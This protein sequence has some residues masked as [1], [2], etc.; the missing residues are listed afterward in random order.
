MISKKNVAGIL[1]AVVVLVLVSGCITLPEVTIP[2]SKEITIT[3]TE[4]Y[5]SQGVGTF[6]EANYCQITANDGEIYLLSFYY[7]DYKCSYS[8]SWDLGDPQIRSG[9]RYKIFWYGLH[10]GHPN[11][12]SMERLP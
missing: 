4:R 7:A 12:N 8:Q 11:I 3:S 5:P 9:Q 1:L 2:E 10:E 6:G